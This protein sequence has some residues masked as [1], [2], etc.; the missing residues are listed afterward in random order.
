MQ[1]VV[2]TVVVPADDVAAWLAPRTD[3]V[4]EAV[5]ED[6]PGGDGDGATTVTCFV[7]AEGPFTHYEREVAVT[8]GT[9]GTAE[10][11]QRVAF[12]LGVP[13]WGIVFVRGMRRVLRRPP[14]HGARAPWWAPPARLDARAAYSLGLLCSIS[15]VGGFLGTIITQTITF[16]AEEFDASTTAQAGALA[17]TRVGAVVAVVLA[18]VADRTGRRRGILVAGVAGCLLTVTGAVAPTL[19]WLTVS[20]GVARGFATAL[21]LLVAIISAEEMPAGSRAYAVSLLAMTQA[22]GAGMCLWVL[23]VA[24]LGPTAWRL[25]YVVPLVFLPVVAA[26]HRRLPESKRFTR[27]HPVLALGLAGRARAVGD[28]VRATGR[29]AVRADGMLRTHGARL[30]LLATVSFLLAVFATPVAQLQNEFLREDRGFSASR[31]TLFTLVTATPGGIGVVVGGRLADV[32]GR[33]WV[34]AVGVIGGTVLTV[35]AYRAQGWPMWV[36]ALFGAMIA[37]ATVPALGVYRP[38]LFPTSLRGRTSGIID[39]IGLAGSAAGLLL[40]GSLVDG[41]GTF[42]GFGNAF[43]LVAIA[44][45]IAIVLVLTRFPETAQREL[46]DLNP[47]DRSPSGAIEGTAAPTR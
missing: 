28:R 8:P 26:V 24:D 44:P 2:T 20:Q 33:R 36:L 22:L 37:G 30:V 7:L 10:V 38:E 31:I 42:G 41:G 34:A 47:E 15:I 17:A 16:A 27:P 13:V 1:R 39:A 18:A 12:H 29:G 25:V 14:T 19:G 6:P 21:L 40:V 5:A 45:V 46:E 32:R 3:V 11:T 4:R 23:P 9:D 43:A 35:L